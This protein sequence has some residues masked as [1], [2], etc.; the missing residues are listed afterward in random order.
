LS[1]TIF[2]F[3][4]HREGAEFFIR[5]FGREWGYPS[6][7]ALSDPALGRFLIAIDLEYFRQRTGKPIHTFNADSAM[8]MA[9]AVYGV[10]ERGACGSSLNFHHRVA[11][12]AMPTTRELIESIEELAAKN[13]A[14]LNAVASNDSS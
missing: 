3:D 7:E 2:V 10:V 4:R 13:A 6:F 12:D 9:L 5:R 11:Q 8:H 1:E 14:T